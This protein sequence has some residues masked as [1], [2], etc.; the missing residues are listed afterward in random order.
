MSKIKPFEQDGL[1]GFGVSIGIERSKLLKLPL[2]DSMKLLR[3][4]FDGVMEDLEDV[5]IAEK[6]R[7]QNG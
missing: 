3:G 5:V 4:V 7:I 1:I 2:E 6:R